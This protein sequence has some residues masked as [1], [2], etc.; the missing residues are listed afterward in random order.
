MT[1]KL[2]DFEAQ[3]GTENS[4][5]DIM[6]SFMDQFEGNKFTYQTLSDN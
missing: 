2:A 3:N 1:A 4:V 6:K 5:K